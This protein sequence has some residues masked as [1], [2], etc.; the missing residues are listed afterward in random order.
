MPRSYGK[1]KVSIWD[2]P[3]FIALP[4][5][6]T[7]LVFIMLFSQPDVSPCGRLSLTFGRWANSIAGMT[8]Q[9]MEAAISTLEDRGFVMVDWAADELLIRSFIK[10]D[11][12]IGN[13]KWRTAVT[14]AL[15]TVRS[16]RL[17]RVARDAF[18]DVVGDET[19]G[20]SPIDHPN[21][22]RSI[23]D[24]I[25]DRTEQQPAASSQQPSSVNYNQQQQPASELVETV[26]DMLVKVRTWKA[27]PSNAGAFIAKR[28]DDIKAEHR[29][30]ITK[31]LGNGKRPK[32]AIAQALLMQQNEVYDAFEQLGLV[33]PVSAPRDVKLSPS[34]SA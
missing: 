9:D 26:L 7:Q 4:D 32:A 19:P 29:D 33:D 27:K 18:Y 5:A 11:A 30:A 23:P 17:R 2:D 16:E 31:A 28:G 15:S 21:D 12:N 8:R 24:P 6:A 3:D 22:W 10:N 13:A 14:N 1:V 20:R 25:P 34:A